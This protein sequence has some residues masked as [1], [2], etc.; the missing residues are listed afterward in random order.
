MSTYY[1]ATDGNDSNNGSSGTPFLTIQKAADVVSAGDTVI[2]RDGT[3]TTTV[4]SLATL[5]TSGTAGNE[6][7]F[8]AE[9]K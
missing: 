5:Y 8:I 4:D 9:N 7:T 1:V 6:I 3:Y 2:I